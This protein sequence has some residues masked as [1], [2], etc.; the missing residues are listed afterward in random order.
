[1]QSFKDPAKVD[2]VASLDMYPDV[3]SK[4]ESFP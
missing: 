3:N 2:R 1:M 4:A